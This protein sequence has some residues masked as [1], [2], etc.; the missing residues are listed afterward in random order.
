REIRHVRVIVRVTDSIQANEDARTGIVVATIDERIG[1]ASLAR[2]SDLPSAG[3]YLVRR[4]LVADSGANQSQALQIPDHQVLLVPGQAANLRVSL[5]YENKNRSTGMAYV[6]N[7]GQFLAFSSINIDSVDGSELPS[8]ARQ[9]R[10]LGPEDPYAADQ[11]ANQPSGGPYESNI[12]RNTGSGFVVGV[13]TEGSERFLPL[14]VF[15]RQA[16]PTEVRFPYRVV[17]DYVNAEPAG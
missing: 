16:N 1:Y 13:L 12:Y 4:M 14:A 10:V 9:V 8:T 5:G 3:S 11:P 6:G 7:T 17:Y 15:Q 2:W